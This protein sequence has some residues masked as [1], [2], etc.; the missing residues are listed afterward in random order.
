LLANRAGCRL[1]LWLP[2]ASASPGWLSLLGSR[3]DRSGVPAPGQAGFEIKWHLLSGRATLKARAP[4]AQL[5]MWLGVAKT[6]RKRTHKTVAILGLSLSMA[7]AG[8]AAAQD[9]QSWCKSKW[10]ADDEKGAANLLNAQLALEAAKLVKTGKVYPLGLETNAK[11]PAYPPA[12]SPL[13]SC[14]RDRPAATDWA[15]PRRPTTTTSSTAG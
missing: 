13:P 6:R 15:R 10:G 11:T 12:R 8:G 4:A 9:A 1:R 7:F 3:R 2:V 14:S 5:S